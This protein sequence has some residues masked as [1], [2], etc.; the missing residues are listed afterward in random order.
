MTIS[1]SREG[2]IWNFYGFMSILEQNGFKSEGGPSEMKM[3]EKEIARRLISI[4]EDWWT[5]MNYDESI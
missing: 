5:L 3:S 2:Q 4:S 1:T